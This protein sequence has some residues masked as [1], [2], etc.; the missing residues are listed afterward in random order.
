MAANAFRNALT[1]IGINPNT[2]A[3]LVENGFEVITDL[4][5]VQ[6][7]DLDKLPKHLS[8]WRNPNAA[9]GDQVRIP[10]VSLEKLKAMRYWVLSERCLGTLTPSAAA[11]T[12]AELDRIMLEMQADNDYKAATADT[13]VN[14]PVALADLSKWTKF[15][16]L[17]TTYL[18]RVKGAAKVPLTYLIRE[19]DVVTAAMLGATY[20]TTEERLI[21]TTVHAGTHYA[22]DNKTL[23]D[24]LKPLVVDGSGWSFIRK[25]D[26]TK[27]GHSAILALKAQAEGLSAKLT[28]KAKAYASLAN[29][30]YRG[31]RR[32]FTFDNYIAVHQEAHNE[33]LDLD[34]PVPESK[35]VTDFLKG[36][37]DSSLQIGKTVIL[38]DPK[39]MGDFEECQ[40]YLG[41]LVQNTATQAKMDR[42]VSS[43]RTDEDG[44]GGSIVDK[45][46]GGS[47]SNAQYSKLTRAEKDRV[48]E[49]RKAEE[50][51]KKKSKK[52]E[53][54]RKRKLAKAQ[55]E[56]ENPDGG[57]V[58]PETATANSNAGAQFG[59]NG[60]SNKKKKS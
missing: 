38:A 41:T 32:G 51:G 56:R 44:S 35:K 23:Y 59:S 22:L 17:L 27:D 34:E 14:K 58:E 18:S 52:K 39:K 57:D 48:A 19:H 33:L 20:A 13:E 4:A 40:Q 29:A 55:S 28:R 30:T 36:I 46:K 24:E 54:A 50:K 25:Y 5:N 21:A 10:F 12:N 31:T 6:E 7:S 60:N 42:N 26:K 3:A 9:P 2:C 8:S 43:V 49:Y 45:I 15:W 47:Y 37:Q 11:F 1:R 53:R 16:E